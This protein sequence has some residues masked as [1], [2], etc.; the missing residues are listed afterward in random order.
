MIDSKDLNKNSIITGVLINLVMIIIF[1]IFIIIGHRLTA[2]NAAIQDDTYRTHFQSRLILKSINGLNQSQVNIFQFQKN[3]DIEIINEAEDHFLGAFSNYKLLLSEQVTSHSKR[4]SQFYDKPFQDIQKLFDELFN[5][6]SI[7]NKSVLLN[8][9]LEKSDLLI[10]DLHTEE[11]SLW[12]EESLKLHEF[13]K[14]KERNKSVFY[15]LTLSFLFI[16]LLLLYFTVVKHKLTKKINFQHEKLVMQDRL[17]TLGMMSAEL[18]H[19][20]NSPLMVID[21]RIRI[22]QN[23]VKNPIG[24]SDLS[25]EKAIKNI[26]IIKRNSQRIQDI[27]KNFKTMSKTGINDPFEE[28]EFNQILEDVEEVTFNK[29]NENDI[30][31]SSDISSTNTLVSVR[32]IQ[33]VQVITNLINNSIDAIKGQEEKWIK[34]ALKE[35][36]HGLILSITDSGKGIPP[37]QVPLI[38]DAF[39]TTKSSIKGTGLGLSISKKIMKEHEGDLEYNAQAANTEFLITFKNKKAHSLSG[40]VS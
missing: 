2:D 29:L 37:S 4:V 33:I 7:S 9:L 35:T 11:S 8:Q 34:L 21:G 1:V 28:V 23:E 13:S 6:K 14:V 20:I 36:Q 38:F 18:A 3:S 5:Q 12:V 40:P 39:Y 15:G 32:K 27:I 22:L 25:K 19:E 16:Q 30:I 26:E 31:F 17:S 10:E 24:F